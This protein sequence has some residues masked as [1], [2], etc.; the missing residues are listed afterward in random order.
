M[1]TKFLLWSILSILTI[2][3]AIRAAESDPAPLILSDGTKLTLMGVTY[4]KHNVA[5]NFEGIGGHI[6]NGNW[7]DRPHDVTVVWFEIEHEPS[8]SPS[9]A[10]LVS[11]VANTGCVKVEAIDRSHVRAGVDVHGFVLQAYPRWDKQF[12][13]RIASPYGQLLSD[14]KFLVANPKIQ[15]F[16]E[17][18]LDTIPVTKSDGDVSVTLTN[19]MA[20]APPPP[21]ARRKDS[22]PDD[23]ANR[24]VRIGYDF[25]QNGHSATNWHPWLVTISDALN[26]RV[27]TRMEFQ[28]NEF[29]LQHRSAYGPPPVYAPIDQ[30]KG[31]YF[32]PGLWPDEPAWKVRLE[33]TRNSG[34]NDDEILTL[35]N[36]PVRHGTQEE[37]DTQ[38]IWE[39]DKTDSSL[40][41]YSIN[42][43]KLKLF[44][45]L[46][47]PDQWQTNETRLSVLLRPDR[48]P[49]QEG[50]RITLL[51][52]T[53]ENGHDIGAG[54]AFVH[55]GYNCSFDF[56]REREIKSVNLKF[57]LHK[58]RFVEF[59]VK[60][61][62]L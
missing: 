20:N 55:A 61:D 43:I 15:P 41:D 26:N 30:Y 47:V 46:L 36:L 49:E 42:G 24:C 57:A 60:P 33:F 6:Q 32:S 16:G 25:K 51:E 18:T 9:Y 13:L 29:M 21:Y 37:W 50:M 23:F 34:F 35:T 1:K 11:D 39:P 48:D 10:L 59:S 12:V 2:N 40:G 62:K 14:Q 3:F 22:S 56:P 45:P 53:D 4:G 28:D 17:Q 7:I 44:P 5:P 27:Q 31:N 38:W 19:L 58:S 52:A 54:S 8:H